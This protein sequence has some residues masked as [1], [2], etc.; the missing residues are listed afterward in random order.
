MT[1]NVNRALEMIAEGHAMEA[2]EWVKLVA[3][4]IP[5]ADARALLH[6]LA[7]AIL[8]PPKR[9]RGDKFVNRPSFER[10]VKEVSLAD[11]VREK[12]VKV[13]AAID[14]VGQDK[15]N[16]TSPGTVKRSYYKQKPKPSR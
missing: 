4:V 13:T 6:V 14:L 7:D 12:G 5:E 3:H 15:Q 2:A 11:K 1:G 8:D 10:F 9:A 16:A